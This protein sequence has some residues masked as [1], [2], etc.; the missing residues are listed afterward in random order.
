MA[1]LDATLLNDLQSY[2]ATNE[3]RFQPVGVV[4]AVADSSKMVDYIDPSTKEA[5]MRMSSARSPQI[6]VMKDQDVVVNQTPGF[7]FI[8]SNLEET[9]Q[10]T[11]TCVDIFSGMRH[12][13]AAYANNTVKSEWAKK[14]KLENICHKMAETKESLLLGVLNSRK[15]QLLDF[16]D[17]I[18]QATADYNF[19][20]GTDILEIKKAAQIDT[21]Y[22]SLNKLMGA[23]KLGGNYRIVTS[24]AGL[25]RP[26]A[27]AAKYG[28]SNDKNLQALNFFG[29]DRMY[30]S[31]S[32]TTSAIFDGYLF[33]D[34][35]IGVVPNYPFDFVN[36]T[37]INGG[38]TS[39][40][41]SDVEAPYL[42]SR[43]NV[44]VNNEATEAESIVTGGDS[45]LKMTTFSEMALW[46]RFYIVYRYNSD[47][48]TRTNDIVKIQGLT[49]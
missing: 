11:F 14:Q 37:S 17:Q 28:A 23:N 30:E 4:D 35:A 40:S 22:Y 10:Y 48:S 6:P 12:Y 9:A 39:W 18:G 38:S 31:H 16:T 43:I 42:R 33:R 32:L 46:D 47:L 24:P 34:G 45:N 19:N 8:P 36:G 49:S 13:E 27:E 1:H 21:M 25:T 29:A 5:M 3:K 2:N 41:I 44:Y 7:T 26:M 15:S 20:T